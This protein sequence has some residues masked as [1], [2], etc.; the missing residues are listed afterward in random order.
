MAIFDVTW[1]EVIEMSGTVEA[2]TLEEAF[3]LVEDD[4]GNVADHYEVSGDLD[5]NT[6]VIMAQ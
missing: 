3:T 1:S 4:F 2:A 5:E 6:V